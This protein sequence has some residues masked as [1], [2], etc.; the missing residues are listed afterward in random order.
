MAWRAIAVSGLVVLGGILRLYGSR[1]DLWLDEILSLVLLEPVKSFGQI[2]W[3]INSENN[4]VL[5][6]MYLY[7]IGPN[8]APILLRGMSIVLGIASVVAAGLI[9]RRD[10]ILGAL[11]AMLLFAVCYPV[12]H[13]G[14][15]AR[16]Y[17]GLILFSL[18]S[19]FFLQREFGR[20]SW[21]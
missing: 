11:C 21:I 20:P 13:Y 6:S 18:P 7:M 2:I 15:E 10:G 1:G 3:G 8:S 17:L 16:G 9:L 14:S 4:H 5:N 12:V 19:L